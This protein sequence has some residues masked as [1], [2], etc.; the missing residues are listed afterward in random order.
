MCPLYK[1]SLGIAPFPEELDLL[2]SNPALD[3]WTLLLQGLSCADSPAWKGT[4]SHCL[5]LELEGVTT[6]G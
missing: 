5:S 1:S 4:C 3:R 6:M 2:S